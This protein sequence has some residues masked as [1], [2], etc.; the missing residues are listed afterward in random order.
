M[1]AIRSALDK[2]KFM[3]TSRQ[4]WCA[5]FIMY[6]LVILATDV[7]YQIDPSPYMTFALTIGSLFILGGSVDSALKIQGAIKKQ[8]KE[9]PV[10]EEETTEE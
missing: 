3:N 7:F 8:D 6:S 1:K 9:P 5:I 2:P 4:W 10:K